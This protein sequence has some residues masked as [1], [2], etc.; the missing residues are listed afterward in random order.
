V[1]RTGT[2]RTARSRRTRELL[3]GGIR[4]QI[5]ES[6]SFTADQIASRVACSPATFYSHFATKD[7]ALAAAFESVLA[8]VVELCSTMLTVEKF[9]SPGV[10]AAALTFVQAQADLFRRESL[11]FRMALSRLSAHQGVRHAYRRAEAATLAHLEAVVIEGQHRGIVASGDPRVIAETTLVLGE[12]L[13]NPRL[14]RPAADAIR[15]EV[16]AAMVAVLTP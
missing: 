7:D 5:R 12:G 8:E 16:A 10:H 1:A 2:A 14:L 15:G 13:N 9:Q 3:V 11:L 4:A 6:G